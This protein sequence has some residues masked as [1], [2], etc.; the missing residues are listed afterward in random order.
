MKSLVTGITEMAKEKHRPDDTPYLS[1]GLAAE[2]QLSR[3][4]NVPRR[5]VQIIALENGIVPER[6]CRNQQKLGNTEQLCLLRSHIAIIGLGGLGGAVTEILA[7]SG[8]GT[9]TLVDGDCFDESNLNRQLLS[10]ESALGKMKAAVAAL[11]VADVNPAVTSLPI[12]HYLTEENG[13][14]ILEGADIAVDCLDTIP[15]RFILAQCCRARNIPMVTGAI[16]G[17]AGQVMTIM[18]GEQSLEAIYGKPAKA[19]RR[20]IEARL[21]TMAYLAVSIA[22]LQCA[23]VIALATGAPPRLVNRLLLADYDTPSL[24]LVDLTR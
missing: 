21:G 4:H 18:P 5:E 3:Q 10:S 22:A 13:S 2:R 8:I 17:A 19:C 14:A 9:L 1:L 7:R 24:D 23:E 12:P 16:G 6:Y 11:R 15:A 20:G